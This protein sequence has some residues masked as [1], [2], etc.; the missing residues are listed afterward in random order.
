MEIVELVSKLRVVEL[1]AKTRRTAIRAWPRRRNWKKNSVPLEQVVDAIEER[2]A[3]AQTILES[4]FAMP[5]AIIDWEGDYRVVLGRSR[6][7]VDYGIAEAGRVHLIALF[8]VGRQHQAETHLELLAASGRTLRFRRF[9]RRTRRR[10]GC[11][12]H[13]AAAVGPRRAQP[14]RTT[15]S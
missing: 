7:G 13:R 11:P 10:Q 9:S 2:E 14:G 3:A 12:R 6:G 4:G 5:H 15:A 8:V 1:T